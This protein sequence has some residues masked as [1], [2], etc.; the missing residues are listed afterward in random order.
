MTAPDRTR[1]WDDDERGTGVADASSLLPRIA[2]LRAHAGRAEWVAEAP[3]AHLWPHLE[4]A[5][6][7]PGSPWHRAGWSI[8]G[9]GCLVVEL[10]HEG[11]DGERALAEVR[12][13]AFALVGQVAETS[14][15]VRVAERRDAAGSSAPGA[16]PD[17]EVD[18]VTGLLDD[19][20]SF[21]SHGHTLRLRI[22]CTTAS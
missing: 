2:G 7:A 5:I 19:E 3:E 14:S 11:S 8:D 17:V 18:V 4:R 13:D 21:A 9:E 1:R 15:F 10:E 16:P 22:T 12:A 6:A 20:T